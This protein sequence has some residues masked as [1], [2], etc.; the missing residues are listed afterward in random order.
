[1]EH[2]EKKVDQ[3]RK[4]LE[5]SKSDNVNESATAAEQA[6]RLMS[7]FSITEAMLAVEADEDQDDT[8]ERGELHIHGSNKLPSWKKLLAGAMSYANQCDYYWQGNRLF[9]VGRPA[10]A[11]TVRY[12]FSFV[13]REIDRLAKQEGSL[14]GSPGRTWFNQFRLGAVDTVSDRLRKAAREARAEMKQIA[15]EKDSMGTGTALVLV[16]NALARLDSR[17][18][19]SSKYVRD[20]VKPRIHNDIGGNAAY[21]GMARE[22]GRKAGKNINLDK[23]QAGRKALGG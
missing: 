8:I 4:L 2:I 17:K 6:Q 20:V 15:D 23:Q 10:D 12:L 21:D 14:L 19:A 13:C 16:N 11:E 9:I 7:K 22:A 18:E 3:V 5:L 1:M